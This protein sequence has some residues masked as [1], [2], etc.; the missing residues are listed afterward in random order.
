MENECQ[1]QQRE[2]R[3]LDMHQQQAWGRGCLWLDHHLLRRKTEPLGFF[4][5]QD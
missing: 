1:G 5:E 4:S 3:G 2:E